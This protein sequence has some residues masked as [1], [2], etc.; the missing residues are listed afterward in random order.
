[1]N[2]VHSGPRRGGW[3]TGLRADSIPHRPHKA[4]LLNQVPV[5]FTHPT[6]AAAAY[7]VFLER[8]PSVAGHHDRITGDLEFLVADQALSDNVFYGLAM[9]CRSTKDAV[10]TRLHGLP[11]DPR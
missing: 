9:R 8:K 2:S 1:M 4:V 7:L 3:S 5:E 10:R 11:N 6:I